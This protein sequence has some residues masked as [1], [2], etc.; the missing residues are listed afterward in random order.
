[1]ARGC[2]VADCEGR[3]K[4]RGYCAKHL[5]RVQRLGRAE[6]ATFAD[7]F[8]QKVHKTETCWL[9]TAGT[10]QG[11][12]Y[13]GRGT[14]AEGHVYAHRAS[15]EMHHGRPIPE[16]LIICHRCDVPLCVNPDHLFVGTHADNLA[17]MR[18]KSRDAPMPHYAGER[19]PAAVLTE[20]D[21]RAIKT[22]IRTHES[23]SSIARDFPVGRSTIEWI[24]NGRTWRHVP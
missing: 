22:R 23:L 7:R 17:D 19:N 9:W 20:H 6:L 15:C 24:A 10:S 1:M 12:G 13:I 11:Y 14:R 18:A 3:H 5:Q 8:W 4:G 21:V 16:G 2:S